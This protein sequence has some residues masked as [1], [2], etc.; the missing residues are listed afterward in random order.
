MRTSPPAIRLIVHADDFGLCAA[1]NRG[2]WRAHSEGVVNAASLVA[3]G[4]ALEEACALIRGSALEPGI[5]LNL[6]SGRPL[7][8]AAEVATLVDREGRLPGKW[9]F[10]RRALTGRL[11][12]GQLEAEAA[13]QLAR[14][15]SLGVR[16]VHL[17]S[18]H[19]VHLLPAVARVLAPRLPGWRI[20]RVRRIRGRGEAAGW[21]PAEWPGPLQ[22]ALLAG[23]SDGDWYD[24][25]ESPGHFW[26][27]A[28]YLS[29]K[30]AA[31]A[32]GL[33]RRLQPGLNE[34]MCHPWH[35]QPGHPYTARERRRQAECDA[36]VDPGTRLL[37]QEVQADLL[38]QET[39][40]HD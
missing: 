26:G 17:D 11:D 16:P 37:L 4:G 20:R 15:I 19:H 29:R 24:A 9:E 22:H 39:E 32:A 27:F 8:P 3:N 33:I 1:A 40:P 35:L 10:F 6:T 18:H 34:W 23:C 36:L 21:W 30:P 28:W 31:A 5:H 7:L 2:I 12:P 13:A 14:L 38:I 25:C